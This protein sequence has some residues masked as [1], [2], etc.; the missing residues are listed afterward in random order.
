MYTNIQH[1]ACKASKQRHP[2]PALP[3]SPH[4]QNQSSCDSA[5]S[6]VNPFRFT[7]APALP[8]TCM[9]HATTFTCRKAHSAHDSTHRSSRVYTNIQHLSGVF[10][11]SGVFV[12]G[13][14]DLVNNCAGP[15]RGTLHNMRA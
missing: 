1:L 15:P 3:S 14:A 5:D 12:I 13:A 2:T 7:G 10:V 4:R 9:R 11:V 6:L 8:S